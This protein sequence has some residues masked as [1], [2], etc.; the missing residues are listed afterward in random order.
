MNQHPD[1][2][3]Q[4]PPRWVPYTPPAPDGWDRVRDYLR[5]LSFPFV[6]LLL[7]G[8]LVGILLY[9]TPDPDPTPDSAPTVNVM[10][11]VVTKMMMEE[12]IVTMRVTMMRRMQSWRRLYRA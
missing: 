5:R 7:G 10:A 12:G 4:H 3:E 6:V 1:D 9:W 8:G 2:Q 11:M